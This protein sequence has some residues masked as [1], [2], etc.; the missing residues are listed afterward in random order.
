MGIHLNAFGFSLAACLAAFTAAAFSAFAIFPRFTDFTG[1]APF[2]ACSM[3]A[4]ASIPATSTGSSAAFASTIISASPTSPFACS[5]ILITARL[6][7]DHLKIN[8]MI[9]H[10]H[11]GNTNLYLI[12][13]TVNF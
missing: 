5:P 1:L 11:S 9:V 6:H 13:D 3:T 2:T 7:V 12:T 4:L 8:R 10:V